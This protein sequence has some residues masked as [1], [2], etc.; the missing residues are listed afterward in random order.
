MKKHMVKCMS[1]EEISDE[2]LKKLN[3]HS[4]D[5]YEISNKMFSQQVSWGK[6]VYCPECN[7]MNIL[8]LK[9]DGFQIKGLDFIGIICNDCKKVYYFYDVNFKK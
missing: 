4:R 5:G 7:S 3:I 6:N 8:V 9:G 1:V 2:Y